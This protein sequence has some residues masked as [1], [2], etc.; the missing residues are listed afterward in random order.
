MC[1]NYWLHRISHCMEVSYPL[2]E[3]GFL[4][5]GFSDFLRNEDFLAKMLNDSAN[6]KELFEQ[7]NIG[8]WGKLYRTRTN[9][10]R[11]LCGFKTGDYVVVPSWGN[12]SV[13]KIIGT[14]TF[15]GYAVSK[16][17]LR[18]WNGKPVQSGGEGNRYLVDDK[19]GII[20]LGFVVPVE[21]IAKDIPRSDYAK[22]DLLSRMKIRQTNADISDLKDSIN[23]AV[24]R[25]KNNNPINIYGETIR[26][27]SEPL[28][29]IIKD[30]VD[31][32]Q[33]ERLVKC[34]FERI[35]ADDVFIPSKRDGEG[36]GDGDIVAR[37]DALKLLVYVQAK[38][39]SGIT[40][41]WGIK[42]ISEYTDQKNRDSVDSD[43]NA[44]SWVISSADEFSAEAQALAIEKNVKL[45]NGEEFRKMLIDVGMAK[46]SNEFIM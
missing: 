36:Y 9:L 41:D 30:I 35:G 25:F 40:G 42:Q 14:P 10:W 20:D 45:I 23:E 22:N 2:L 32:N 12:F 24:D 7:E 34:Y 44:I 19:G 3:K 33:F 8:I 21:L 29:G 6:R 13:W 4:S 28:K 17:T 38:H 1:A 16:E 37:F 31:H 39:H 27:L 11:F 15:A 18:D 43:Y 46:I 5:I 26:R